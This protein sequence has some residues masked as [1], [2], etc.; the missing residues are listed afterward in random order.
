MVS[1]YAIIRAPFA[2]AVYVYSL[3]ALTALLLFQIN[4]MNQNWKWA[5]EMQH[6]FP[7]AVDS[8]YPT[9]FNL[10]HLLV[11]V[12]AVINFGMHHSIF[13]R[14]FIKKHL[15]ATWERSLY[16]FYSA[17]SLHL[18]LYQWTNNPIGGGIIYKLC[19][20]SSS[21]YAWS[22]V[23]GSWVSWIIASF[24]IS[25]FELFGLKQGVLGV[26]P[27]K[28]SSNEQNFK[29]VWAYKFI[30]HP[31]MTAMICLYWSAPIMSVD[32]FVFSTLM[33]VYI[34]I[35]VRLEERALKKRFGAEY[36]RYCKKVPARFF[37]LGC[38]FKHKVVPQKKRNSPRKKKN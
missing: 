28:L 3:Y 8:A 32:R 22:V 6:Y 1:E 33:T 12:A 5:R 36:T 2:I 26:L 11:N 14:S 4:F 23:I 9:P 15:P 18:M 16:N 17:C 7:F 30:R 34:L 20:T 13:A 38:P 19:D 21:V 25:H 31:M 37:P 27:T 10:Y 35:G 24:F 29:P